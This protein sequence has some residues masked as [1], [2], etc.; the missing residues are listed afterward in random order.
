M[1]DII[2]T[3]GPEMKQMCD[4]LPSTISKEHADRAETIIQP[5][6]DIIRPGDII[7]VK[8]SASHKLSKVV[9]RV[10]DMKVDLNCGL[11]VTKEDS[12]VI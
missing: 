3:V 5:L 9:D 1:V 8:G 2:F 12:H 4:R 10:L 7:L 6:L 11:G